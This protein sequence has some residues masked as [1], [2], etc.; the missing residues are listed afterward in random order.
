MQLELL[1]NFM[2]Y[3]MEADRF[4]SAMRNAPD[5][6]KL[7]KQRDFLLELQNSV[8]RIESEIAT[9]SD[10]L[11]AVRDEAK[12]LQGLLDT[13]LKAIEEN[14]PETL[15]EIARQAAAVQRLEDSLQ[16]YE[17]ELSKM[18]KDSEQRDR[19]QKDIRLRYARTKAEYDALKKS[20][21]VEFG[22]DKVKLAELKARAEKEAA[23]VDADLMARYHEVKQHVTPP[24]A[25]LNGNRCGC[26]NMSMPAAVMNEV[27]SGKLVECDNCGRIL[28]VAA[29]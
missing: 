25:Q 14:P 15:E 10:R 5:R 28:F 23:N 22:R 2:Q 21:E 3:D 12:R 29:K 17:Q 6:V 20:Y 7:L 4:E 16:H 9:M 19:Q 18:R 8:K 27:N 13:Q 24:I 11:E 1:W 26:C